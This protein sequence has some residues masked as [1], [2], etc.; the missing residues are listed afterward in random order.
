MTCSQQ[1]IIY[2]YKRNKTRYSIE[3]LNF[4]IHFRTDSTRVS[5]E[6]AEYSRRNRDS[7]SL[8][9]RPRADKAQQIW[10]LSTSH[11][12]N[13]LSAV[14]TKFSPEYTNIKIIKSF[15]QTYIYI[16]QFKNTLL[17]RFFSLI[18]PRSMT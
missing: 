16:S 4:M 3:T 5:H 7:D 12:F 8:C 18:L 11:V 1:V 14:Y 15:V 13:P 9:S 17:A 6:G 2:I 10:G